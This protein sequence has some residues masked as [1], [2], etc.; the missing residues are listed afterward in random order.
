MILTCHSFQMMVYIWLCILITHYIILT[1]WLLK[2][3]HW[4]TVRMYYV[5]SS[6]FHNFQFDKYFKI[7]WGNWTAH[8]KDNGGLH[9][10]EINKITCRLNDPITRFTVSEKYKKLY[11]TSVLNE[12]EI[13]VYDLP[14]LNEWEKRYNI[15][16]FQTILIPFHILFSG[17]QRKK[18][19]L[20]HA[21]PF[22]RF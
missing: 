2:E 15:I 8:G 18:V 21:F 19:P 14:F 3:W 9:L 1:Y 13:Y 7:V 20:K 12:N 17:N 6:S 11:G 4:L 16:G 22:P 5:N 10:Q